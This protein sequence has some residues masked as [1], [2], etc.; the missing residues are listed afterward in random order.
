M[1]SL[2]IS[3]S[4]E[5]DTMQSTLIPNKSWC[6]LRAKAGEKGLSLRKLAHFK[7]RFKLRRN[8]SKPAPPSFGGAKCTT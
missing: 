5:S 8:S 1:G 3:Q 6:E 2:I 4:D 7:Q